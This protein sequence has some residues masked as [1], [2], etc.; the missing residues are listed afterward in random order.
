[1]A[2][3]MLKDK[4]EK[5]AREKL[6]AEAKMLDKIIRKQAKDL[7]RAGITARRCEKLRK[8]VL[9]DGVEE[10]NQ[11]A[12]MLYKPIPN[13]EAQWLYATAQPIT[14]PSS[15]PIRYQELESN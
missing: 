15:P 10:W 5:E 14:P 9:Q 13:P 7:K 3:Q 11:G 2:Q 1:M 4:D 12:A 6:G 8:Q